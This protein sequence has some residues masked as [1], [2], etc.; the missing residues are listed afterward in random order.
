M[1]NH[2]G[3]RIWES[4]R[5]GLSKTIPFSLFIKEERPQPRQKIQFDKGFWWGIGLLI[6][7]PL[8]LAGAILFQSKVLHQPVMPAPSPDV[9]VVSSLLPQPF[10][11]ITEQPSIDD[12]RDI[13]TH[14][15]EDGRVGHVSQPWGL[16]VVGSIM[17]T[18]L[19]HDVCT[20]YPDGELRALGVLNGSGLIVAEYHNSKRQATPVDCGTGE[21]VIARPAW[22][23]AE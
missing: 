21:V 3:N 20:I 13:L 15:M 17:L 6:G 1:S 10:S 11:E 5:P 18:E 9:V 2:T 23:P 19:S 22:F 14:P 8:A 4:L 16:Q 7:A 12:V